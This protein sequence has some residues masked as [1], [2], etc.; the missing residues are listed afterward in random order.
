MLSNASRAAI[1]L[2]LLAIASARAGAAEILVGTPAEYRA[3][4]ADLQPGD[5]VVLANGE[6]RDFQIVFSGRGTA[7]SPIRLTGQAAGK[8]IISGQS[9]LRLAGEH[10]V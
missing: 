7:A 1:A 5:T 10:L 2:S 3:A 8:V 9:N 4:A 6:W